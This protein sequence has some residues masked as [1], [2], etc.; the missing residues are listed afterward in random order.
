MFP[1]SAAGDEF[2]LIGILEKIINL[3]T[4]F[5]RYYIEH[6]QIKTAQDIVWLSAPVYIANR[7]NE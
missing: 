6:E 4:I 7:C 2:L 3:Q 5:L 1:P